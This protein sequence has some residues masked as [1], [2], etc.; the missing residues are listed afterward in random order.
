MAVISKFVIIYGRVLRLAVREKNK[1]RDFTVFNGIIHYNYIKTLKL[2][3]L[4]EL[5]SMVV[6]NHKVFRVP[7]NYKDLRKGFFISVTEHNRILEV[8]PKGKSTRR[9]EG[10]P[11][12]MF[13]DR[14]LRTTVFKPFQTILLRLKHIPIRNSNDFI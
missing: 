14:R 6:I 9:K 5:N 10:R 2:Q 4:R 13:L 8:K 3:Y 12:F 11:M 1:Q 7:T